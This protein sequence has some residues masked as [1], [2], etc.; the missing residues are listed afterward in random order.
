MTN[1]AVPHLERSKGNILNISSVAGLRPTPNGM[2]YSISKA[3]L[4]QFTK[5]CALDLASKG[6]RVNSI[7][8][9][10]VRSPFAETIG[11]SKEAAAVFFDK[12]GETYPLGR[13]GETSDV[14]MAIAYLASDSASFITGILM[15]LDGGSMI[16][17]LSTVNMNGIKLQF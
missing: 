5:C 13:V 15:P 9:A 10:V 14:S 3:G 2:S 4:D 7:N 1:L 6:I 11:L 8:A 17:G 16:N 12:A